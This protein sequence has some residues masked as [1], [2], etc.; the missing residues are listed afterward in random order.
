MDGLWRTTY[1]KATAVVRLFGSYLL[2]GEDVGLQLS[3]SQ[4]PKSAAVSK[5]DQ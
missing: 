3:A 1:I 2:T 4:P 5:T